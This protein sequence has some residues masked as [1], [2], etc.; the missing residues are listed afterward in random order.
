MIEFFRYLY[1]RLYSWNLKKWGEKDIPHFNAL[2]G[3]TFMMVMNV[4]VLINLVDVFGLYDLYGPAKEKLRTFEMGFVVFFFV[5]T[6]INHSWLVRDRKYL[7]LPK[8]YEGESKQLRLRKVIVLWLYVT[9]SFGAI[10][11]EGLLG[12]MLH[13]H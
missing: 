6:L 5:L 13:G 1:Y 7:P 12:G 9:L 2:L 10:V 11:A 3:V 8:R 4:F